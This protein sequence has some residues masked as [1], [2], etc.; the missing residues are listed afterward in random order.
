LHPRSDEPGGRH[1]PSAAPALGAGRSGP[2]GMGRFEVD[3]CPEAV[4]P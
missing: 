3:V 2:H 4:A 1:Q